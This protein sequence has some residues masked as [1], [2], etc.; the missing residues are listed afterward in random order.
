M[1]IL[2]PTT[3]LIVFCIAA[4]LLAITLYYKLQY[5][6]QARR[7]DRHA[8]ISIMAL[9]RARLDEILENTVR[10]G[11]YVRL[12]DIAKEVETTMSIVNFLDIYPGITDHPRMG[13]T[14]HNGIVEFTFMSPATDVILQYRTT[15]S[16]YLLP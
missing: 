5:S 14:A 11:K 9:G 10:R 3:L 15:Q 2:T 6:T 1:N 8:Q 12:T 13:Y 4:V 7:L 16:M